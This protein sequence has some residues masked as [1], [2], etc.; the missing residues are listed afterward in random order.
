MTDVGLGG[1]SPKVGRDTRVFLSASSSPSRFGVTVYNALFARLGL[2]AV[3]LARRVTDAGALATALRALGLDGASVSMPLK[4]EMAKAVDELDEGAHATQSVNTVVNRAGRLF[5][6]NTDLH[7]AK[8]VLDELGFQDALVYGSGSVTD[9]L[10][11]V[12]SDARRGAVWLDARDPERAAAKCARA[13]GCAVFSGQPF[14]LFINATPLSSAPLTDG[15]R[16]LLSERRPDIFDLVV[17]RRGNH[18]AAL[19]DELGLAYTSGFEMYKHQFVRQFWLY[20]GEGVEPATVEA[21][22]RANGLV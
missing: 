19:A 22:A 17:D 6:Y 16:R 2:D 8:C 14:D 18:L 15:L 1:A 5:G 10:L 12:L 3:Y 11:A 9:S 13:P 4:H 20:T 7:G 21:I